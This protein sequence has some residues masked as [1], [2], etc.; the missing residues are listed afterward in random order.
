ML[1]FRERT[2]FRRILYARPTI[3]VLLVVTALVFRG[4]WGMY[5]KKHEAEARRDSAKMELAKQ[6]ERL[7]ELKNDLASLSSE[8][9]LEE[10]IRKR[11]MVAKEGEGM[12]VITREDQEKVHTVTIPEEEKTP[13]QKFLGAVGFLDE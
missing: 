5:E 12:I 4:V 10:E 8:R 7:L 9:G 6:E 1:D 2:L 3:A 11:F 13:M